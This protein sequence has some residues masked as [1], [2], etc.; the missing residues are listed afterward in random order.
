VVKGAQHDATA[1]GMTSYMGAAIGAFMSKEPPAL[2]TIPLAELPDGFDPEQERK[3]AYLR[4]AGALGIDLQD[5]QPLSGQGLGTGTQSIMLDE[6]A[7]G[8][9]LA[10]FRQDF[11]HKLNEFILDDK[12]TFGFNE[13]DLRDQKARAEVSKLRAD[14]RATMI[15]SGE[16]TPEQSLQMAVDADDAPREFLATDGTSFEDLS[17][18]EKPV[19]PDGE[20]EGEEAFQGAEATE[21]GE[22]EEAVSALKEAGNAKKLAEQEEGRA[23]E[24]YEEVGGE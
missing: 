11:T 17:D 5:L 7:S 10:A 3:D 6:K 23:R 16:I 21:E 24:L 2:V 18:T 12:T 20:G 14:T 15:Q 1:K 19:T 8:K 13:N 4:Y 22:E 9:G